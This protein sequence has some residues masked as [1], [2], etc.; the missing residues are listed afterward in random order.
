MYMNIHTTRRRIQKTGS[1]TFSISMPK[2]WVVKN[3][4]KSGDE[5]NIFEEDDGTLRINPLLTQRKIFEA[6]I[7]IIPGSDPEEIIRKFLSYYVNMAEKITLKG[8]RNIPASDY[9]KIIIQAKKEIGFEVVDED[10]DMIVFQDYFSPVN[11][12]IENSIKRAYNISK[13]ILQ[14]TMKGLVR[15]M[16]NSQNLDLWEDEVDRIYMLLRRQLNFAFHSTARLHQLNISINRSQQFLLLIEM[17]E[18]IT[19]IF[20]DIMLAG[21]K[22][23]RSNKNHYE[24]IEAYVV[25]ILTIY[26]MSFSSVFKVDFKLANKAIKKNEDLQIRLAGEISNPKNNCAK[27]DNA[28]V[29]SVL[30]NLRRSLSLIKDIAEIGLDITE[31]HN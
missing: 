14:E 26:E 10:N 7:N 3:S 31:H 2:S 5:V 19:D 15:G 20:G 9:N 21:L 24:N 13:L 30:Y 11:L 18:K 27:K 29:Y 28:Q 22:I 17:I 8:I 12:A 4:L 25:D 6:V 23:D 1:A 16:N